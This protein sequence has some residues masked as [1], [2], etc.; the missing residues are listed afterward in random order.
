MAIDDRCYAIIAEKFNWLSA[1]D[2]CKSLHKDAHLVFL[3]SEQKQAAVKALIAHLGIY[4]AQTALLHF[5]LGMAKRN[6]YW[7]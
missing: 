6:A 7:S 2:A 4:D 3:S 1:N 5:A